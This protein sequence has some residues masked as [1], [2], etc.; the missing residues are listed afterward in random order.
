MLIKYQI[1][2]NFT[3]S[4]AQTFTV[5]GGSFTDAYKSIVLPISMN[6]FPVDYGEDISNMV[7]QE[8]K[9]AINP[10]FDAETTKYI[11]ED[12]LRINFKFWNGQ[13]WES[14][15]DAAGFTS[16]DVRLRK[17]GFKKSF[18]RLYFYDSNSG[19]TS[20]LIFTEDLDVGE[21]KEPIISFNNLYWLRNDKF[22]VDSN[23]NRVVYME[24][25]FFD[26][27]TGKILKFINLPSSVTNS[28][29]P[30]SIVEYSAPINRG[31]RTV[32]IIIKNPKLNG[33]K[34]NFIPFN[35]SFLITLSQLVML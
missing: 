10:Y 30:V 2:N 15:Y 23:E 28:N 32:P 33:G 5:S 12:E 22:F 7:S 20:N 21:T 16:D 27:K 11:S 9:K 34:Y 17:N 29:T 1:R 26:A 3:T 13:V 35:G 19:E 24:A 4:S 18:F 31:W 14:S 6:F 25:R 8:R